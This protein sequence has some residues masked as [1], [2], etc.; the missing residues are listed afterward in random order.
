MEACLQK[1]N[2]W[3]TQ[4]FHL[5]P[6]SGSLPD[7]IITS[8]CYF[9][10]SRTS[11]YSFLTPPAHVHSSCHRFSLPPVFHPYVRLKDQRVSIQ[12]A[13]QKPEVQRNTNNTRKGVGSITA[14]FITVK[15]KQSSRIGWLLHNA[16]PALLEMLSQNRGQHTNE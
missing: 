9:H 6:H 8:S 12:L 3:A 14:H 13:A 5:L 7:V 4:H 2:V 11:P 15:K 1:L 10:T 16:M